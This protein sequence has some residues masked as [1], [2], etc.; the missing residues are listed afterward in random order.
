[1]IP[2]PSNHV[3]MYLGCPWP[4]LKDRRY[5]SGTILSAVFGEGPSSRLFQSLREERGLAYDVEARIDAYPQVSSLI[6]SAGVERSNL[7]AAIDC[8][9]SEIHTFRSAPLPQEDWQR[10]IARVVMDLELEGE[11]ASERLSRLVDSELIYG[12][13]ISTDHL[14]NRIESLTADDIAE[15]VDCLFPIDATA[16]VLAGNVD[17]AIELPSDLGPVEWRGSQEEENGA[18]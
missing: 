3:S 15:L 6:V 1:M 10:V 8:I 4:G 5:L 18:A 11:S 14:I 12:R 17:D 7:P 2:K 9:R 13:Y 16:L